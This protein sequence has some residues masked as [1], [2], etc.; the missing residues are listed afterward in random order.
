MNATLRSSSTTSL[1][2]FGGGALPARVSRQTS[3]CVRGTRRL[4][5]MNQ[6]APRAP[7]RIQ[8]VLGAAF[9]LLI[10][11]LSLWW[12]PRPQSARALLGA[13]SPSVSPRCG[14]AAGPATAVRSREARS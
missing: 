13:R 12:A 7:S 6:S 11:A 9:L 3:G 5:V 10:A 1:P 4:P 14:L 2:L 8:A